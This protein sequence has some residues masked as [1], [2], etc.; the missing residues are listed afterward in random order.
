[1][2]RRELLSIAATAAVGG[3]AWYAQQDGGEPEPRVV[4]PQ[5]TPEPAPEVVPKTSAPI[6]TA[7][8][9][10][11]PQFESIGFS[12]PWLSVVVQPDAHMDGYAFMH[13]R[14]TGVENALRVKT[15]KAG[16]GTKINARQAI[17]TSGYD[18]F[19]TRQFVLEAYEGSFS[20]T[21][22]VDYIIGRVPVMVPEEVS[23]EY[24][25]A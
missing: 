15:P 6:D 9:T 10:Q 22:Q 16:S 24:S 13:A 5:P 4:T 7:E 17:A 11:N 20:G 3:G 12:W 1:M 25:D 21:P 19:P 18:T 2:R 23:V 14:Q 8:P